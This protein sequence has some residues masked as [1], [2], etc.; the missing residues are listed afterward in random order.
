MDTLTFRKPRRGQGIVEG[1][2]IASN[3]VDHVLFPYQG[4]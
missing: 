3:E 4:L 1:T 2:A